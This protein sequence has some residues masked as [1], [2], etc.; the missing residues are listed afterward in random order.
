MLLGSLDPKS[1]TVLGVLNVGSPLE[2]VKS[3]LEIFTL[4]STVRFAILNLTS[5][6]VC[7]DPKSCNEGSPRIACANLTLYRFPSARSDS[8]LGPG[9]SE[10]Q[11]RFSQVSPQGP[12]ILNIS[13]TG[14]NARAGGY[15]IHILPIKSAQEPCS[16]TNIMGHFNPNG[17]FGDLTGQNNFQNQDMDGNMPLS[18]PNSIIGRSLVIHYANG[19]RGTALLLLGRYAG[20][21]ICHM[22]N[23][24]PAAVLWSCCCMRKNDIH[25]LQQ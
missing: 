15:H 8:W 21:W 5:S 13:F 16:D 7:R 19:S 14:L 3:R 10:G 6:H 17:T 12:T 20:R 22:P 4:N 11:V 2:P 9:T 23:S 25:D 1:L 18:G 24:K